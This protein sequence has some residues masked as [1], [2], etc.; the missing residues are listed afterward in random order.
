VDAHIPSWALN[1]S[2]LYLFIWNLLSIQSD[3]EAGIENAWRA[4]VFCRFNP[5]MESTCTKESVGALGPFSGLHF[6]FAM[7]CHHGLA[8]IHEYCKSNIEKHQR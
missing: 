5:A 8:C 4:D 6:F 7:K 3:D 1:Q 2:T